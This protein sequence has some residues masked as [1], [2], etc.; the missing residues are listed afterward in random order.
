M[1]RPLTLMALCALATACS[2][3]GTDTTTTSFPAVSDFDYVEFDSDNA[4]EAF[5]SSFGGVAK[6]SSVDGPDLSGDDPAESSAV[7]LARSLASNYVEASLRGAAPQGKT[8]D[9]ADEVQSGR[10]NCSGGGNLSVEL[11]GTLDT[12]GSWI[13]ADYNNCREGG[14]MTD[15]GL[16]LS[17]TASSLLE[18][19]ITAV[20]QRLTITEAG[21]VSTLNGDLRMA[22][23]RSGTVTTQV[24][25]SNVLNMV[26]SDEGNT[27][28]KDLSVVSSSDSASDEMTLDSS[29]E[30]ASDALDG[31]VRFDT[32]QALRY[33]SRSQNYPDTGILRLRG[34]SGNSLRLDADTGDIDTV[35]LTVESNGSVTS[36]EIQWTSIAN[37]DLTELADF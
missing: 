18:S 5:A 19:D 6:S 21:A 15:G 25:S 12:A 2:D 17:V 28:I 13:K 14:V 30:V 16:Q 8:T 3:T 37:S 34:A 26:S 22:S 24:L 9:S 36:E 7:L 10:V 27:A 11:K 1:N 32:V 35:T 29:Y 4:G 20:Y 33:L 31:R 23:Q